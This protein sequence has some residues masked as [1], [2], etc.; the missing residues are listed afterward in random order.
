MRRLDGPLFS[1]SFVLPFLKNYRYAKNLSILL[2]ALMGSFTSQADHLSDILQLTV[3][4]SGV[5]EV[6]AV[7]TDAQGVG[8]FT[9]DSRKNTLSIDVSVSGLS[10]DITGIHFHEG[11]IG[12]NGGV[13]Q[14]IRFCQR[15]PHPNHIERPHT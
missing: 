5:N 8:I 4:M 10:G 6:P 14:P 1:G 7:T 3:R 11:A 15:Q 12:E 2:L 13:V 9:L